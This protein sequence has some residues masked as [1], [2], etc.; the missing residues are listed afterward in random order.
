[1]LSGDERTDYLTMMGSDMD[2]KILTPLYIFVGLIGMIATLLYPGFY[3]PNPINPIFFSA[4][5]VFGLH[6][7]GV[8]GRVIYRMFLLLLSLGI[9]FHYLLN[10]WLKNAV[11]VCGC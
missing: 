6:L 11:L 7:Y 3:P 9:E 4:F 2:R 1:M 8:K 5:L 10:A